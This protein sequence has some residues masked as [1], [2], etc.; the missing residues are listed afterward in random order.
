MA[1]EI[2]LGYDASEES[3]AAV[4][5]AVDLAK[6]H[7]TSLVVVFGYEPPRAGGEVGALRD[8]IEKV[9][10]ELA[11]QVIAE[12]HALAADLDVRVELVQGRPVDSLVETADETDAAY[13]VV[14]H[15]QRSLLAEMFS[16]SVLEGVMTQTARPVVAVQ[17]PEANA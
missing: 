1:G 11:D 4:S 14:G 10:E 6:V 2:I 5:V 9:G 8:E 15:R 17:V 12:V 16:G 7:G 13:I 3:K